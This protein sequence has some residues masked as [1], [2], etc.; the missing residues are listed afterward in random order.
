M[1][2]KK[3]TPFVATREEQFPG[4]RDF[5]TLGMGREAMSFPIFMRP[6]LLL[7]FSYHSRCASCGHCV[8]VLSPS[9]RWP[10]RLS[11]FLLRSY[12]VQ[13]WKSLGVVG[14]AL[15]DRRSLRPFPRCLRSPHRGRGLL[16]MDIDPV[17]LAEVENAWQ[18]QDTP[19][20]RLVFLP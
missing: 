19:G 7:L 12:A 9:E 11:P 18:R 10:D 6:F 1:L 17:P 3:M 15:R 2:C 14:A 5:H 4:K 16:R 8:S 20:R 13:G